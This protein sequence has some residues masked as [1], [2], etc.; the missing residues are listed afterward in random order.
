[1]LQ[2]REFQRVGG[3]KTLKLDVRILAATNRDLSAEVKKGSFREDLFHRLNVVAIRM[4]ALRERAEDILLLARYFLSRSMARCRRRVQG[5]SPEAERLLMQ[6][7]WPG[8]V[9]ELENSVE[10]AV[11]LGNSD[12]VQPEDLPE[13]LIDS[14]PGADLNSVYHSSVG[15]AKR[16]SIL[17]AWAQAKGDYKIA[18]D[19]LGLHPN[20][21]LRLIR[22]LRLRDRLRGEGL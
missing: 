16:E 19:L 6:Y 14:L 20:S 1:V 18:A 4:P 8:N 21:L 22:N 11:V 12:F 5:F 15:D 3:M 2:Q 9:R 17:R 13:D 10:R 7:N